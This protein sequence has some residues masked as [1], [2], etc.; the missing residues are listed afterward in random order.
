MHFVN[1]TLGVFVRKTISS[2]FVQSQAK[3]TMSVFVTKRAFACFPV[4][5]SWCYGSSR[6]RAKRYLDVKG[7][8]LVI[9]LIARIC[10]MNIGLGSGGRG[11]SKGDTDP[12]ITTSGK[13]LIYQA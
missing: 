6:W 5:S 13:V 1:G 12:N 3:Y 2:K 10:L 9:F 8:S 7:G 4:V 11:L